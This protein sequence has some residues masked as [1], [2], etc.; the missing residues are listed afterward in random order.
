MFIGQTKRVLGSF[1]Q[2]G[3]LLYT[4]KPNYKTDLF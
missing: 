3:Q 4:I 2:N 1:I